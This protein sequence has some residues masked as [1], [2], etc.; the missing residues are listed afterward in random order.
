MRDFPIRKLL[1]VR[2]MTKALADLAGED[3]IREAQDLSVG[4]I[5]YRVPYGGKAGRQFLN[6]ASGWMMRAGHFQEAERPWWALEPRR[7]RKARAA[8]VRLWWRFGCYGPENIRLTKEFLRLGL[9]SRS[10]SV[11]LRMLDLTGSLDR[12]DLDLLLAALRK[13][14]RRWSSNGK[15]MTVA[16]AC[17]LHLRGLHPELVRK[18][19]LDDDLRKQV[20]RSP[21]MS[22]VRREAGGSVPGDLGEAAELRDFW[23]R[24]TEKLLPV[25]SDPSVS[26]AVVG[27]SPCERGLGKGPEIDSHDLVIRFNASSVPAAHAA[28][29]GSKISIAVCN[30]STV[31]RVIGDDVHLEG[32]LLTGLESVREH[33]AVS[34]TLGIARRGIPMGL[35]PEKAVTELVAKLG[36]APSSGIQTIAALESLRPPGAPLSLYGFAF[37]D[38]IGEGRSSANFAKSASATH[39]HN[40]R[41]ERK[42]FD[43]MAEARSRGEHAVLP[44]VPRRP[45]D[46]VGTFRPMKFRFLGDHSSYH[47]GS[48]AVALYFRRELARSGIIVEDDSYDVLVVNGE[49]SMHHDSPTCVRKMTALEEA[50]DSGRKGLLI[51][52]VWEENSHR[53]DDT[54]RRLDQI[55]VRERL[56]QIELAEKHGIG[57]TLIPDLSYFAPVRPKAPKDAPKGKTLITDFYAASLGE[58]AI[59]NGGRLSK[60]PFIDMKKLTWDET[61]GILQQNDLVVTG[62]HHMV[63][64]ACRARTPFVAMAGNTHKIEGIMKSAGV[65]IPMLQSLREVDEAIAWAKAN[66]TAYDDLFDWL[67][68]QERWRLE[69]GP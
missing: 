19:A 9:D 14:G 67:S 54:L 61:V 29:Y 60:L 49:G 52:T 28:D 11:C 58:F 42:L 69:I 46:E 31:S 34:R 27:N 12:D 65:G 13:P 32:I 50:L 51:N 8:L 24:G 47:G 26:I 30:D 1:S 63:Y 45:E 41:G 4:L 36:A 64:A 21:E 66:R 5:R 20:A 3:R 43:A 22:R 25:L 2:R 35:L 17:I 44:A 55:V 18:I 57:S 39:R 16:V 10:I 53:F 68:L 48:A 37:T 33:N 62:R 56:S 7:R 23:Q 59:L 15:T 38:Q 6:R 40:W